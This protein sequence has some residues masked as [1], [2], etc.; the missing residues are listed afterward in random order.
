MSDMGENSMAKLMV[1]SGEKAKF[2]DWKVKFTAYLMSLTSQQHH[3]I[4][5][6]SKPEELVTPMYQYQ[7]WLMGIPE[8]KDTVT[9]PHM[10]SVHESYLTMQSSLIRSK[11]TV[12]LPDGYLSQF[13]EGYVFSTPIHE[14]WA[15]LCKRY[16]EGS[17]TDLKISVGK[18]IKLPKEDFDNVE[19]LFTEMKKSSKQC[20]QEG[21]SIL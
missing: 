2:G 18:L 20:E 16:G 4:V 13:T 14:I 21:E 3:L 6:G 1:F 10:R 9:D 19:S 11:F 12:L 5:K 7:D 15:E 8:V 17:M